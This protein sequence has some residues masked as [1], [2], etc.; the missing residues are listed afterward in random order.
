MM[1]ELGRRHVERMREGLEE[2]RRGAISLHQLIAR[3]EALL[4]FLLE[5]ADPEWVGDMEAEC[6]RLEFAHA[7]AVDERRGISQGEL[8]EVRDATR[9][10]RLMLTRF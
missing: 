4:G 6:N 5:E 2:F 1:S 3:L 8:E 10:L 7:A 9:Q